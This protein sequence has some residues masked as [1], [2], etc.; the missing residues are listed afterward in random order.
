MQRAKEKLHDLHDLHELREN[1]KVK[2]KLLGKSTYVISPGIQGLSPG[3]GRHRLQ[4]PKCL[5]S[6]PDSGSSPG[7]G[8]LL[9]IMATH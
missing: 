3:K 7:F 1:F 8:K 2:S 9:I 6:A 5:P 4:L